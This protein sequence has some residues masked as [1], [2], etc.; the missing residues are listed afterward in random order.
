[1]AATDKLRIIET[2][3]VTPND[4][5]VLPPRSLPFTFFDVEWLRQRPQPLV[6]RLFFYRLTQQH[7]VTVQRLIS[8]VKRSLSK[9]LTHFYPLAGHVRRTPGARSNRYELFY[10]PGDGVAFTVAEYGLHDVEDYLATSDHP[11]P[12]SMLAPLVPLLP[13]GRAVLAVQATVLRRGGLALGVTLHHS[14]CD[15]NSYTHFLHTWAAACAG[16]TADDMPPPPV[17]DRSLIADRNSLYDIYCAGI[18]LPS[19]GA[20][21]ELAGTTT[22]SYPDDQLLA[23]FTLSQELI[24]SIKDVLA[25]EAARRN[26]PTPLRCSSLLAAYSFIWSCY[27]RAKHPMDAAGDQA[28]ATTYFLFAVDH[29]RRLNPPVPVRYMG[30]CLSPAIAAAC[31]DELVA[32]TG[33]LFV[34]FTAITDALEQALSEG[35]QERWDMSM[36]RVREAAKAGM[37]SVAGS[38]RFHVYDINFGFGRPAKVYMVS[39]ARTGGI[40][41]AEAGDG[42]GGVEFG[43]PLPA[44]GMERFRRCFA[45]ANRDVGTVHEPSHI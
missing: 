19:D 25:A 12:V 14:A 3:V 33:G 36:E 24:Q 10:Q 43:I 45:D 30:N 40:S 17:I 9:A 11:V 41:V 16:A 37:L 13:K 7:H 8:D 34:A 27:C 42:H 38:P 20:E 1:M 4:L 21:I 18:P 5:S 32:A 31:Q 26:A 28:R 2:A 6:Q 15:G 23:T 29:R 35:S 44:A 39:A 22:S